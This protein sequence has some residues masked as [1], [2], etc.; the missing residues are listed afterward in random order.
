MRQHN[1]VK[2]IATLGPSSSDAETIRHLFE[3]GAD[4]FRLNFSHGSHDDHRQ[5]YNIIRE[6]S[7]AIQRPIGILMDLQGPKL[8]IGRFQEGAINLE[9]GQSFRLDLSSEHG[10][11]KRAPMP[12]PEI[13]AA[14]KPGVQL[15]LDDGKLRLKVQQCGPDFAE[16]QVM[17][18][19][20]LS[21]RKGVNVPDVILNLSAMTEKD[22][23][24]LEF[25]LSLGV[26]WVALSFVQRPDDVALVREKVANRAGIMAK[27]EKPS[28]IRYLDEIVNHADAVMVARGDLGVELPPE[29]VPILQK[30]IIHTCREAGKPVVV[31][32]QM[33]ESMIN[34]PTPTRAEASD[35]AGAVYEGADAVMLSGESAS[36]KYPREAVTIMDKIIARVERDPAYR[37]QMNAQP[38]QPEPTAG[39]AI[40]SALSRVTNILPVAATVTYT[41]SGASA[42]RV[43]RARPATPIIGITPHA[44]TAHRLS[45]VWGVY[46]VHTEDARSVREMVDKACQA[47]LNNGFAQAGETLAIIA[48]MP[49]GSPGATNI[50]RIA[51]VPQP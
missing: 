48:G 28:A 35:V 20:K 13:F 26:D 15:L 8:R 31:A 10:D 45:L 5:R 6:L 32:T 36:G 41:S 7:K 12:H 50:L 14:L 11:E 44:Q 1:N 27:I 29:D 37:A 19:G 24:D 3:A 34:A 25:G 18:G 17:V 51:T 16:T 38:P 2:I 33:L 43:A 47:A 42:L 21:D 39:D 4:V 9:T 23:A 22:Q 40:S 49:F 46:P 30:Q